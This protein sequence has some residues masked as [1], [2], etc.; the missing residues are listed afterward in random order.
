MNKEQLMQKLQSANIPQSE[1]D[2]IM[3][4]VEM[5]AE[6]KENIAVITQIGLSATAVITE[7]AKQ[8]KE[9]LWK[10]ILD[11]VLISLFLTTLIFLACNKLVE[12]NSTSTLFALIIGYVLA[13]FKRGIN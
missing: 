7:L 8:L 1:I 2:E 3:A 4:S 11:L 9:N 12:P 10:S 13:R 5:S 6:T